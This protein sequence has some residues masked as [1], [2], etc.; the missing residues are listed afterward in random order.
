MGRRLKDLRRRRSPD[1]SSALRRDLMLRGGA[2][3]NFRFLARQM[4]F[5]AHSPSRAAA[6]PRIDL[7]AQRAQFKILF[8]HFSCEYA[9]LWLKKTFRS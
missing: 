6:S 3:A 7:Q 9:R 4:N 8:C 1:D 2:K 5:G